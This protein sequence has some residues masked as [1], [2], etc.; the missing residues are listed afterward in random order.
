MSLTTF[1]GQSFTETILSLN[2]MEFSAM[3]T[4]GQVVAG[5]SSNKGLTIIIIIILVISNVVWIIRAK[6]KK[7]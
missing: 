2:S 1:A 4:T 7:Q 6:R 3:G 5:S